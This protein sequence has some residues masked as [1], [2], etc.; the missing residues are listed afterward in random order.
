VEESNQM[1]QKVQT[2]GGI[3]KAE[4]GLKGRFRPIR[5]PYAN[6]NSFSVQ[7]KETSWTR[8]SLKR[9]RARKNIS[10]GPGGSP[11]GRQA[12]ETEKRK[13]PYCKRGG[14]NE[15]PGGEEKKNVL[16]KK[17]NVEKEN[18]GGVP[19]HSV[20]DSSKMA[21]P[22]RKQKSPGAYWDSRKLN[23]PHKEKKIERK[24]QQLL[25]GKQGVGTLV[26][27]PPC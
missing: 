6:R 26:V 3:E 24:Q 15:E 8:F 17:G 5:S 27:A 23:F 7:P 22:C 13:P 20:L 16:K 10:K 9:R 21:S 25:N 12:P 2:K 1:S 19:S 11:P 18:K 4:T 14:G